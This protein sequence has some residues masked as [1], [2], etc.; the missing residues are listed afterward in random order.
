M[1]NAQS[2]FLERQQLL[3]ERVGEPVLLTIRIC[4]DDWF[5]VEIQTFTDRRGIAAG[6]DV[7]VTVAGALEMLLEMDDVIAEVMAGRSW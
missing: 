1:S 2:W 7:E 5:E 4:Y 6:R 3:A